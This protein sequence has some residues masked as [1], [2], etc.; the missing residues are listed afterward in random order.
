MNFLLGLIIWFV[1]LL[2][3]IAM[4]I[5]QSIG[6]LMSGLLNIFGTHI[7]DNKERGKL[8]VKA[9]YFIWQV[10]LGESIKD[11]NRTSATLF[12]SWSD[13]DDDRRIMLRAIRF[14]K[15]YYGGEQLPVIAEARTKGFTG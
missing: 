2:F 8:F 3:L 14:S 12:V 13:P 10:D 1:Q 6:N 11:A 4:A 5:L 15:E 7:S 9:Y